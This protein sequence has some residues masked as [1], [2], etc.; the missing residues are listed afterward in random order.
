MCVDGYSRITIYAQC[1]NNQKADAVLEQFIRG[2]NSYGLPSWVRSD[3]GMKNFKVEEFMLEQRGVDRGSIIT[4]SS[5]HNSCVER[6]HRDIYSVVLCFL[7]E[8]FLVWRIMSS[9]I[10]LMSCI[11]LH[12]ITPSS[13]ESISAYRNLRASGKII[14]YLL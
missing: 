14:H 11:Y 13:S 1:C 8:H 3:Y 5:V 9:W 12:Y 10:H 2:D 6:S 4:G 7:Q